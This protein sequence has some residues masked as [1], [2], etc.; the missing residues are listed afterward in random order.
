[1][2]TAEA[3]GHMHAKGAGA[4]GPIPAI[5]SRSPWQLATTPRVAATA[6]PILRSTDGRSARRTATLDT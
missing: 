6:R 4:P 5:S 3:L 1:M 2:S